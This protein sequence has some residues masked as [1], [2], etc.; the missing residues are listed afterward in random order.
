MASATTSSGIDRLYELLPAFYRVR[1]AEAGAPLRDLLRVI[2]EQVNVVEQDIADLYENWF[3]ETAADWAVPY[4]ADLLGYSTLSV[5]DGT[6]QADAREL[7][8]NAILVPRRDV[9]NT[10]RKYF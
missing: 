5:P 10:L 1:D 2:A 7:A 6:D 9:A 8:R 4:I 3:V